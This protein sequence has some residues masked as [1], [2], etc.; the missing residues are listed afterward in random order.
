MN[1]FVW[2]CL[3]QWI[4]LRYPSAPSIRSDELQR[5]LAIQRP[6]DWVILDAR[7]AAEFNVSHLPGAVLLADGGELLGLAPSKEASLEQP[8]VVCCSVGLR[9]AAVVNE[10][11]QRGFRRAVNLEGGLFEW[12]NHG[13]QLVQ[14]GR[15]TT[16]VH[17]FHRFWGLLLKPRR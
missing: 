10:L 4:R 8:I 14:G 11:Q 2:F 13:H 9:S 1:G 5:A 6:G 3:K 17:P 15:P 16:E 12:V 7:T